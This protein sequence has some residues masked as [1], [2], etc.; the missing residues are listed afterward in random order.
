MALTSDQR[1]DPPKPLVAYNGPIPLQTQAIFVPPRGRWFEP[2]RGP[3][4]NE[5]YI[6]LQDHD[7][8]FTAYFKEVTIKPLEK[9]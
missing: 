9:K 2:D 6:G 7:D 4:P 3:R 1:W 8:K 5:G